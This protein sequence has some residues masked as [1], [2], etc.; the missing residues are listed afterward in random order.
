MSNAKQR[1]ALLALLYE[2][3]EQQPKKGWVSQKDMV[4][5]LGN[6][7]FALEILAELGQIKR[8]GFKNRI[9]G[10]GVLAYENNE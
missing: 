1:Q 9:T 10:Q 6:C 4:D 5:A 2:A 3:R 8:D 7:D